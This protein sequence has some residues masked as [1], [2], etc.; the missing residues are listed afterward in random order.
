MDASRNVLYLF[1]DYVL[2]PERRELLLRGDP[3]HVE[4]QVFD[5]LV[6]LIRNR[7][8]VVSKEDLI[9]EIWDG[10]SLS[11]SAVDNRISVARRAIG[12][13]GDDQRLILTKPRI[14]TRFIGTVREK[15][16]EDQP[17]APLRQVPAANVPMASSEAG[18]PRAAVSVADDM[19]GQ[20]VDF[21]SG[22][23]PLLSDTTLRY[24][25]IVDALALAGCVFARAPSE[26]SI[27]AGYILVFGPMLLLLASAW[28]AVRGH[29]ATG[30]WRRADLHLARILFSLP[31]LTS[32]FLALQ[33]FLLLA[34][35]GECPTFLRWKY[36]T[37]F[38]I[39][40]FKPEYCMGLDTQVQARGPWL[41]SPVI[42]QAWF[43]VLAPVATAVLCL[44]AFRA[45]HSGV[46]IWRGEYTERERN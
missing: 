6:F 15:V 10:R 32:A 18:P 36:L 35:P 8:R 16:R 34:P 2:D 24:L 17:S 19:E 21:M 44:R 7:E 27:N 38:S 12:D 23:T 37:D 42:L 46:E 11:N 3:V 39:E 4:P 9:N 28:V 43:Q 25:A 40:A 14:G 41:M 33:F 31:V 29:R 20:H 22:R 1:E 13:S 5:L 45:W 30:H 26:L